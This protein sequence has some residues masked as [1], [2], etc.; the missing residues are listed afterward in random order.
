MLCVCCI[1]LKKTENNTDAAEGSFFFFL[2]SVGVFD[3]QIL[4]ER[5]GVAC[6]PL[7]ILTIKSKQFLVYP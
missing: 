2:F 3:E 6:L 7:G 1:S 4:F 5:R